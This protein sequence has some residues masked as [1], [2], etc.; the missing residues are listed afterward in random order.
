MLI[1]SSPVRLESARTGSIR[2]QADTASLY[3]CWAES[4]KDIRAAQHLRRRVFFDE[5]G[6]R[7][8]ALDTSSDVSDIDHFDAYCD[9][10]LIKARGSSDSGDDLVVG[11]YRVLSPEAARRAGGYYTDTEFDLG[12]W[13][14]AGRRAVELGRSCVHPKWRRGAVI[15]M[16]W[17]ALGAYMQQRGLS[18]L[19]GCCSVPLTDRGATARALWNRLSQTH[20]VDEASRISPR[21]P[22]DVD[23]VYGDASGSGS[24]LPVPALMKGYLRCGARLLGPPA[25]D[26]AFN[27]ADFPMMLH[28]AD[29]SPAYRQH[30]MG[31]AL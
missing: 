15:M 29:L 12:S 18:T 28:L 31:R 2:P 21:A 24:N 11:T 30:F 25:H 7:P 26:V 1:D 3:A 6:A 19:I 20:L 13:H 9:H 23:P 27:T 10:L 17:S 14:A 8:A 22:F 5:M 4:A 16:L